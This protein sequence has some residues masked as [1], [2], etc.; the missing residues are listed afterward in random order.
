LQDII[1][2]HQ[3]QVEVPFEMAEGVDESSLKVAVPKGAPLTAEVYQL[4]R[5]RSGLL[6]RWAGASEPGWYNSRIDVGSSA[7]P[8]SV[9][10]PLHFSAQVIP[11]YDVFPPILMIHNV[12]VA[13]P[14]SR[15]VTI[16]FN[17]KRVGSGW[18]KW[19]NKAFSDHI[20]V[21]TQEVGDGLDVVLSPSRSRQMQSL[22]GEKAELVIGTAEEVV[23]R[24]PVYVGKESFQWP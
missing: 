12:E 21:K 17:E 13:L 15:R 20:S 1:Q 24:I 8:G 2:N 5:G 7:W 10:T 19:S 6:I 22:V 3:A 14:W 18:S 4:S 9:P 16:K 11:A 23:C